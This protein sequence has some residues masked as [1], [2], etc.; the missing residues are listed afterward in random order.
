LT[1]IATDIVTFAIYPYIIIP[2]CDA[3]K[4]MKLQLS[5]SAQDLKGGSDPYAVVAY[6]YP[7]ENSKPTTI[8]KTEVIKNAKDPDFT[9]MFILEEFELGKPMHVL[10]TIRD[11]GTHK[12][13]GCTIFEVGSILGRK[14]G[15]LGKEFKTG[16]A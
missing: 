16:G 10:V 11:E 4:K 2:C 7:E 13:L 15:I 9:K 14:G 8:G 5:I 12:S 6:I 3:A 1:I